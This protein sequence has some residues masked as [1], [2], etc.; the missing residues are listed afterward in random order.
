MI[1]YGYGNQPAG[2]YGIE[3]RFYDYD[4]T[5]FKEALPV[6][7]FPTLPVGGNVLVA[8]T[9]GDKPYKERTYVVLMKTSVAFVAF[10]R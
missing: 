10:L 6:S 5:I 7:D 2:K 3:T 4:K 8:A 9:Y 1:G